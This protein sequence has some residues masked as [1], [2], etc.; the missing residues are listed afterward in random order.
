[1]GQILLL[2]HRVQAKTVIIIFQN[3]FAESFAIYLGYNIF[4]KKFN[5]L[6]KNTGVVLR[7]TRLTKKSEL[8]K[9][10]SV[11]CGNIKIL[12]SHATLLM[13]I[14]VG[15]WR[16]SP[17]KELGA[18]V[19]PFHRRRKMQMQQAAREKCKFTTF[20]NSFITSVSHSSFFRHYYTGYGVWVCIISPAPEKWCERQQ[21]RDDNSSTR[22]NRFAWLF[23]R[24]A[25]KSINLWRAGNF[26]ITPFFKRHAL[27]NA[28]QVQRNAPHSTPS[29]LFISR[30]FVFV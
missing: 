13:C 28:V 4:S 10:L 17:E 1:M 6:W 25:S 15:V 26:L 16:Q 22:I 7:L 19:S 21:L 12:S 8:Q 23:L 11:P 5:N 30:D 18:K 2:Y 27:P 29:D 3:F 9:H 14:W 20:A 24:S